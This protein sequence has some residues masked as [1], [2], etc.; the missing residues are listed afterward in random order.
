MSS[1]H[2]KMED[3]LTLEV[4]EKSIR[5]HLPYIDLTSLDGLLENALPHTTG[6][7]TRDLLDIM[8][9]SF[10]QNLDLE[11]VAY[12]RARLLE[13]RQE[14]TLP[15]IT[16][17]KSVEGEESLH[18]A[19]LETLSDRLRAQCLSV[20]SV[21]ITASS[22]TRFTQSL[23]EEHESVGPSLSVP[24][25]DEEVDLFSLLPPS[26]P[27]FDLPFQRPESPVPVSSASLQF[28]PFPSERYRCAVRYLKRKRLQQLFAFLLSHLLVSLPCDPVG[29]LIDLIDKLMS[30]R[31]EGGAPPLLYDIDHVDA[32][33][34][35]MDPSGLGYI[36]EEQYRTAMKT[37][38]VSVVVKQPQV[39]PGLGVPFDVYRVDAKKYLVQTLYRNVLCPS[40]S[41]R[42][43]EEEQSLQQDQKKGEQ[44]VPVHQDESLSNRKKEQ[45]V[46]QD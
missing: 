41:K 25:E 21:S 20:P 16:S 19:L 10:K 31:D 44:T 8:L 11:T 12:I 3:R 1:S 9:V 7:E 35:C 15:E 33:F 22:T 27:S 5:R 39:E 32:L 2:P 17:A 30:C 34:A 26:Q 36:S 24:A 46:H 14:P 37:L 38:G 42:R 43:K 29:Y 28:E 23:A 18:S 6:A 4:V 13:S 45:S 40:L